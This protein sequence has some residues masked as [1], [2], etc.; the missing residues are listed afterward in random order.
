MDKRIKIISEGELG[1]RPSWDEWFMHIPI[2][3]ASRSSCH[4]VHSASIIVA[5][6]KI[7]GEGYNGAPSQIEKNCLETGC[8]KE[9]QG[10]DYHSSLNAGECIGIHSEMNALG[11]LSQINS[12]KIQIYNTIF[13]CHTC[14]K[15]LLPYNIERIIF[16]NF[17]SEKEL[18]ST[19]ELLDEA[20]IDIYRLDL[21]PERYID[22]AFNHPN[23]KFDVW[24]KQ[25]KER[26]KKV[27]DSIHE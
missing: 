15:N 22:I 21:S 4:N 19:L 5:N 11:H 27:L 18:S 3:M 16:K 6:K 20:N 12:P 7:I 9:L 1:K 25:E 26:M 2:G 17:Y 8:R 24:S 14:A 13:P 10:L 23:V